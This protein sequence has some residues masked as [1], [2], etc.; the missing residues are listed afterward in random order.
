VKLMVM[1]ARPNAG[2]DVSDVMLLTSSKEVE[3]TFIFLIC[4]F[5]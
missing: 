1:P 2:A 4:I 5:R 3:T